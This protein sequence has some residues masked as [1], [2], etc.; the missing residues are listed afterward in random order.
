MAKSETWHV[1]TQIVVPT[2]YRDRVLSLAHDHIGG[3]LCVKKTLYKVMK[4][5]FWPG[6][7]TNVGKFCKNCHICQI[8]GK[9]NHG[10]PRAPLQPNP[11]VSEPFHRVIIDCVGPLEKTRKRHQFLLTVVDATTRYPEAI[12]LRSITT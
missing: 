6:V 7:S 5:L 9:P 2:C 11:V 3:H 1:V 10:I 4:Y 8:A 12:P